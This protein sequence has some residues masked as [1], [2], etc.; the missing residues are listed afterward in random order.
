MNPKAIFTLVQ[1]DLNLYFKNRFF[2]FITV[3]A[4]VF[5][6]LIYLVLP[7]QVDENLEL[8]IYAAEMPEAFIDQLTVEGLELHEFDSPEALQEGIRSGDFN[9]GIVLPD[10]YVTN[11]TTGQDVEVEI[12]F[13]SD[14]PEEFQDFYSLFIRE[15]SYNIAG[16]PL[17][18]N[19]KEE[20]LGPDLVGEQIPAR[21]RMLPLLSV[22]ILMVEMMGLASLITSEVEGRTIKALLVTP[23]T[24]PGLFIS[25]GIMGTGLAFVQVVILMLFTGG[26]SREPLLILVVLLLGSLLSTALA[27]LIASIARDMMSVL[28]WS[29]LGILVLAIPTFN[30]LLPG[31]ISDW[32]RAVPSYYLVDTVHRVVNFGGSWGDVQANL[33]WLL[34]FSA[35]FFGL[36]IVALRRKFR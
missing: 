30:V 3:L 34:V 11:L 16:K 18:V 2:A 9:V 5:Y 10:D 20:V 6:I 35:A 33:I 31:T 17:N 25:K 26:F 12:Y 32:V 36:G 19:A 24:V 27:F 7:S 8:A 1:K 14:F 15:V 4:L 21:D 29:I 28:G 23:L 22:F 13:A